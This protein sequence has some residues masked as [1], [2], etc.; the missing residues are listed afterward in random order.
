MAP[1]PIIGNTYRCV[2]QWNAGAGRDNPVSVQH[3]QSSLLDASALAIVIDAN[4]QPHQFEGLN[5]ET[6]ASSVAITKLDGVSAAVTFPLVNWVGSSGT[7]GD[8]LIGQA[9]MV[10]GQTGL[11]GTGF[12]G[13]L[14][15]PSPL[16]SVVTSGALNAGNASQIAGAWNDFQAAMIADDASF[17][18]ASYVHTTFTD[19]ISFKVPQRLGRIRRRQLISA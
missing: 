10:E 2:F 11:R 12:R 19:Y 8:P 5:N 4:V 18:V 13:R 14:F 3:F 15:L 6:Q 17:G 7:G 16:E 9:I 1:L